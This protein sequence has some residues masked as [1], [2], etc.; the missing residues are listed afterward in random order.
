MISVSSRVSRNQS[1]FTNLTIHMGI[2]RTIVTP[3]TRAPRWQVEHEE[4]TSPLVPE[5]SL[6]FSPGPE[7]TGDVQASPDKLTTPTVPGDWPTSSCRAHAARS[8][9]TEDLCLINPVSPPP[10]PSNL[11]CVATTPL[12]QLNAAPVSPETNPNPPT[13]VERDNNHD[14]KHPPPQRCPLLYPLIPETP[15]LITNMGTPTTCCLETP[16]PQSQAPSLRRKAAILDLHPQYSQSCAGYSASQADIRYPGRGSGVGNL[17]PLYL[18]HAHHEQF[19][20]RGAVA[21]C[22]D[23]FVVPSDDAFVE[24]KTKPSVR[25]DAA[26]GKPSTHCKPS[27]PQTSP[28]KPDGFQLAPVPEQ[29]EVVPATWK[30]GSIFN[31][32]GRP[33]TLEHEIG[34]GSFGVVWSATSVATRDLP[35]E[36]IAIKVFNKP[37]SLLDNL[38]AKTPSG[39][40]LR[41]GCLEKEAGQIRREFEILKKVTEARS[42]FL[43]PLLRGFSDDDNVYFVMRQYPMN[44]RQRLADR[45]VNMLQLPQIKVWMA[46]LVLAVETL[47]KLGIIHQDLKPDNI[48]ITPSGHL[49]IADFGLSVAA[50]L[51]P[52]RTLKDVELQ[53]QGRAG[54][55]DYQA[56]EVHTTNYDYKID[57]YAVGLIML[58]MYL[59]T[60][61]PW[62]KDLGELGVRLPDPL[63]ALQSIGE[64]KTRELLSKLLANDPRERPDWT[65]LREMAY[66][67]DSPIDWAMIEARQYPTGCTPCIHPERLREPAYTLGQKLTAAGASLVRELKQ[68]WASRS[69]KGVEPGLLEIDYHCPEGVF[70]DALHGLS[71]RLLGG[72]KCFYAEAGPQVGLRFH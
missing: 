15:Q 69:S 67:K 61:S 14:N 38:I 55:I 43:T 7:S 17:S 27:E 32:N 11:P 8:D 62:S 3:F 31:I 72:G 25:M 22:T 51:G 33:F 24:P 68:I 39:V 6:P 60:G 19:L 13:P 9:K 41:P 64:P 35:A 58:E 54:T 49:C 20:P 18:T 5:T 30:H 16:L 45:T 57:I 47:H 56:P 65:A 26:A 34:S 40:L 53:C 36:E 28:V 52:E 23:P 1:L 63:A 2:L 42:P 48:L 59:R 50:D 21:V 44:L 66:F 37:A 70:R 4:H 12:Q 46:E 29:T 10:G 71:C